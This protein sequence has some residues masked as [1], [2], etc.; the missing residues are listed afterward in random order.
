[1]L[2][3]QYLHSRSNN[4]SIS[5]SD[6]ANTKVVAIIEMSERGLEEPADSLEEDTV[7]SNASACAHCDVK[8]ELS[9]NVNMGK[10]KLLLSIHLAMKRRKHVAFRFWSDIDKG[11]KE[12]QLLVRI[13]LVV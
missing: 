12:S 1:M 4:Y 8:A 13:A 3:S 10:P 7:G 11:T 5:H 6:G 9:R 2:T